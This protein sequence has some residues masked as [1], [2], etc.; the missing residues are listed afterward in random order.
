MSQVEFQRQL[1]LRHVLDLERLLYSK[2]EFAKT[3]VQT[4]VQPGMPERGCVYEF[5]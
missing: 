2:S 5:A 4:E 3:K 1:I